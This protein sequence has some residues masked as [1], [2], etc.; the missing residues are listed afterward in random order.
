M[1]FVIRASCV[2]G[3]IALYSPVHDKPVDAEPVIAMATALRNGVGSLDGA[4]AAK[5]LETLSLAAQTLRSLPPDMRIRAVEQVVGAVSNPRDH[6][7]QTSRGR[8]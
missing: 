5:G 3:V 1:G 4:R 6:V 7:G 8:P 2:I